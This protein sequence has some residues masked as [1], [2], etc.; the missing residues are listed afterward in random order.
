MMHKTWCC[1]EEVPYRFS[2]SFVQFQGHTAKKTV[3]FDPNWA[4]PDCN[5][6]MNLP[7]AMKWCTKIEATWERCPINFQGHPLNFKVTRDKKWSILNRIKRFRT[8]TPV[9]SHAW[10]WNDAQ[11][12]MW[13]RRCA[14]LFF[15]VIRRILR[16]RGTKK[17]TI[18]TR[19]ERFRTV[20]QVWLHR[21]I[22][23]DAQSLM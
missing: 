20:T 1:L 18:L 17:S 2:R 5:S 22:W 14:L 13:Y 19:I 9:W 23:S 15:N 10:L 3:D 8:V 6:S 4:F 16:S 7:M 21:W 11:S 12:I